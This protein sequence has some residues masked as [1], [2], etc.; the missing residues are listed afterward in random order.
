ML[1]GSLLGL[2]IACSQSESAP[3]PGSPDVC[4]AT[5]GARCG[6]PCA[7]DAACG[8]GLYCSLGACAAECTPA[9]G[10]GA[11]LVCGPLGRCVSPSTPPP[12]PPPLPTSPPPPPPPPMTCPED[13]TVTFTRETP[14]VLF[15][16]DQS[17]SMLCSVDLETACET[18]PTTPAPLTRWE[19][20]RQALLSP[21]GPIARLQAQ[22][23]FGMLLYSEQADD[24]GTC[25]DFAEVAVAPNNYETIK[26]KYLAETTKDAT[27]TGA[28]LTRAIERLTQPPPEGQKPNPKYIIL[29]TDGNP[30]TCA[31]PFTPS[32]PS[33]AAKMRKDVEDEA[34]RGYEAGVTTLVIAVGKGLI[35]PAHL[36]SLALAGGEGLP[37]V[38][39][40]PA[41]GAEK[42]YEVGNN[43]E[44]IATFDEVTKGVRSCVIELDATVDPADASKGKVTLDGQP[45]AYGAEDGWRLAAPNDKI[46]FV[47]AACA[48]VREA[49][50]QIAVAFQCGSNVTPKTPR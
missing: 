48:K 16:I 30:N 8:G 22:V 14:D 45:V 18:A 26:A 50:T 37:A 36:Q 24:A 38:S 13:V 34:R 10:C 1:A 12:P 7:D 6:S 46:E 33:I 17:A 44:L 25:P 29:A 49:S 39:T 43:D 3:E 9:G 27:P 42:Y 5:Y 19:A 31:V 41:P 20:L 2:G 40:P 21:T 4:A 47:G 32:V 28:A 23:N 15:V 11:G 35:D